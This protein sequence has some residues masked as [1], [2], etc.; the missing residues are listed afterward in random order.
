MPQGIFVLG[1]LLGT[2][3]APIALDMAVDVGLWIFLGF[4]QG[5]EGTGGN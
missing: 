3:I 1:P 5:Y 2:D 4:D